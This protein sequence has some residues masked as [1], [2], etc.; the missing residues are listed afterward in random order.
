[1]E[2]DSAMRRRHLAKILKIISLDNPKTQLT[3]LLDGSAENPYAAKGELIVTFIRFTRS[4]ED[5]NH[6][7]LALEK[8]EHSYDKKL[9]GQM[10]KYEEE[11]LK[12]GPLSLIGPVSDPLGSVVSAGVGASVVAA[13]GGGATWLAEKAWF[14]A[15][16]AYSSE[17][18][19]SLL[20]LLHLVNQ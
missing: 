5:W 16:S 9:L 12:R 11:A 13:T 8:S 18:M 1:M 4:R 17:N 7:K 6:I 14:Q 2:Y 19:H 20:H 15:Q 3:E 10:D